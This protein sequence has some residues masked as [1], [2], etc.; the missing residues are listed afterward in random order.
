[1]KPDH[2]GCHW[3]SKRYIKVDFWMVTGDNSHNACAISQKLGLL[4]CQIDVILEALPVTY[5]KWRSSK[6]KDI[7]LQW[8]H[9]EKWHRWRMDTQR[10]SHVQETS[11]LNATSKSQASNK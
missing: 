10:I 5:G 7:Q 9:W 4:S 1:L 6:K 8:L 2:C 11:Q 3:V